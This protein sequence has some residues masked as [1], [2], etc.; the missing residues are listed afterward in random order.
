MN[1][2][3]VLTNLRRVTSTLIHCQKNPPS[4]ISVEFKGVTFGGGGKLLRLVGPEGPA[5]Q[6][7]GQQPRQPAT[8]IVET[9]LGQIEGALVIPKQSIS[10]YELPAR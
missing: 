6:A 4:R 5:A 1:G 2:Q 9:P 8:K 3:R 10:I 7:L